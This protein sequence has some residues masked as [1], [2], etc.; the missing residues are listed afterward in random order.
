MKPPYV[1]A[2]AGNPNSGKTTIF[3]RI[4]GG[5]QHVGNYPGVTVD[6]KESNTQIN[7]VPVVLVDLPGTYSL[8]ALSEEELV[9]RNFILNNKP[10]VVVDI[11]DASTLERQLYLAVQLLELGVPMVLGLNMSDVAERAGFHFDLPLLSELLGIP[12]V[13]TI[14]TSGKGIDELV[15]TALMVA[16]GELKIEPKRLSY[17]RVLDKKI[18]SLTAALEKSECTMFGKTPSKW[19]AIKLLE[20]DGHVLDHCNK[21]GGLPDPVSEAL[22][23]SLQRLGQLYSDP[24]EIIIAEARYGIISGA[25]SE[26]VTHSVEKR[27]D[28]SDEIDKIFINPFFGLPIF[29]ILMYIVFWTTFTVGNPFVTWLETFF[30]WLG[31]NI[32][33]LFPEGSNSPLESLLVDGIIG[34][35]GGVVT[36]LPNI[37]L[38][39]IAIAFLEDSGYMARAAFIM[40]RLMH[41]IGL[42]GKSFIPMLIGFGCSIPAI[43]GTRILEN[44]RDRFVTI[45]VIP[46]MSCG[47]RLAIYSLIIPAFFPRHLQGPMLW[48]IYLIGIG[49]AI[50]LTKILRSTVFKGESTPFVMELPPYRIPTLQALGIHSWERG[51][52]YLR[53]AGTI[54]LAISILLWVAT[55]YPKVHEYSEDYYSL[56]E[57]QRTTY[58]SSIM[59]LNTDLGL[60]ADYD[61][62]LA[63]LDN[64]LANE[65]FIPGTTGNETSDSFIQL[66]F[67][68]Q[69]I[70]A[71]FDQA[72]SDQELEEGTPDYILVKNEFRNRIDLI[73][74]DNPDIYP[75]AERYIDSILPPYIE[76]SEEIEFSIGEEDLENSAMGRISKT[77]EPV[78][79][80]LGFDWKIVTA[81]LGALAAK[82][83]F[84][85][86]LGIVYSM[87][88]ADEKSDTLREKLQD[89]YNPLIGFCIMLFS[90]ISAPCI[91]TL[92]IT[93]A[94]TKSWGLAFL[95]FFGLTGLAWFITVIVYQI[96]SALGWGV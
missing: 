70:N 12:I 55:S 68:I 28:F 47:A 16:S 10:D 56:L 61:G 30:E 74:K 3:N 49:L 66:V 7:G 29:L 72:V 46:L 80:P 42:H 27:H 69:E 77:I 25:A 76:G 45:M 38:L 81:T 73:E 17:G 93:R 84:V 95:Q 19:V 89:N 1:I 58:E 79:L 5:H 41:K 22:G 23:L 36:F 59:E 4:T 96:G 62:I 9:A 92:A 6:I 15:N 51:S 44:K 63:A 82:E 31:L 18:K 87:G 65:E 88:E 54:I 67:G 34:G 83:V 32:S 86:Q 35:V 78:F 53:K 40:D 33:A 8:S 37:L 85:A 75:S 50:L 11:V 57:S 43:M 71:E 13:P 21:A 26:A 91:A 52:M 2:L 20:S 60:A 64:S 48:L 14:G 39:F 94:E 90:L 24:P